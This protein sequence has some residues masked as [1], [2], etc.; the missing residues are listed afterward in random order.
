MRGLLA[1]SLLLGAGAGA[2]GAASP[3]QVVVVELC[4][5]EQSPERVEAAFTT[6]LEKL[7]LAL[8]GVETLNSNTGYGRVVLEIHYKGGA[9][10]DDAASVAQA[11]DRSQAG[12]QSR[13]VRLDRPRADGRY[14]GL[15]GC[16]APSR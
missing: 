15:D 6:P 7:L 14:F 5:A 16:R 13:S 12:F 10:E 3:A 2:Q 8:P 4:V 9:S 11:I 1:C